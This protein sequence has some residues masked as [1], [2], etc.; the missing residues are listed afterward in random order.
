MVKFCQAATARMS[1]YSMGRR[2]LVAGSDLSRV[3]RARITVKGQAG[4]C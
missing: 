1:I 3:L 4:S 2:E